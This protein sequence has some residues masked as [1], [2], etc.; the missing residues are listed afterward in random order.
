MTL[1]ALCDALSIR[2]VGDDAEISGL[3]ALADAG[4]GEVSFLENPKYAS[5]SYTLKYI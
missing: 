4:S 5:Y 1:R 2:F 3:N